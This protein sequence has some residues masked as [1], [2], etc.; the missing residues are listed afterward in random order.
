[1]FVKWIVLTITYKEMNNVKN[2]TNNN[3][4]G[5]MFVFCS[6]AVGFYILLRAVDRFAANYNRFPGIFDGYS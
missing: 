1:M 3:L 6:V 2:I 5:L 4:R